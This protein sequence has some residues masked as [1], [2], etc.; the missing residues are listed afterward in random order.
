[1]TGSETRIRAAPFQPLTIEAAA[2]SPVGI[3]VR[4]GFERWLDHLDQPRVRSFVTPLDD[5]ELIA[6]Y[7]DRRELRVG[8]SLQGEQFGVQPGTVETDPGSAD[9]WFPEGTMVRFTAAPTTGFGFVE[10]TGAL[11][12]QP[13]PAVLQLDLPVDA[14]ALFDLIYEVPQGVRLAVEAATAQ[15]IVLVAENGTAPYTWSLVQGRLPDGLDLDSSGL[16]RGAPMEIGEFGLTI[17]ARDGAGLLATGTLTLEV[18]PPSVGVQALAAGFLGGPV[19]LSERQRQFLD[20]A[21]NR[22]GAYDLGDLRAFFLA[23]PDLPVTVEERAFLRAVLPTVKFGA[24]EGA[25]GEGP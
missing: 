4:L 23:N 18:A 12:G 20:R 16:I 8:M 10:W 15:E 13:N 17:Q 22:N 1:V 21:G 11:A 14:G 25:G 5:A 2:G 19:E 6:E 24:G 9:L 7:G 3:G